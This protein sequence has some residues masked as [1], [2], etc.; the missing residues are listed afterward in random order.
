MACN[1]GISVQVGQST[2]PFSGLLTAEQAQAIIMQYIGLTNKNSAN[3]TAD[4]EK[5]IAMTV[6]SLGY[7]TINRTTGA[8]AIQGVSGTSQAKIDG[9]IKALTE[10][11]KM[12]VAL[13]AQRAMKKVT[14][15]NAQIEQVKKQVQWN[16]KSQ[17]VT[18][19]TL[20]Y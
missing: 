17:S 8:I 9:A 10:G 18:R 6:A 14:G 3:V 2:A 20:N 7:V 1:L 16:G 4:T 13:A 19:V 5:R 15:A 12:V 11:A